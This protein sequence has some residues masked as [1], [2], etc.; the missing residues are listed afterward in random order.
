MSSSYL[1]MR[2][3]DMHAM[4]RRNNFF[5][6]LTSTRVLVL[7]TIVINKADVSRRREKL[8]FGIASSARW[9]NPPF[10]LFL[11]FPQKKNLVFEK[12]ELCSMVEG[13]DSARKATRLYYAPC[14]THNDTKIWQWREIYLEKI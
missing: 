7:T 10:A 8:A 1:H 4:C 6:I 11:A 9:T 12:E 5:L 14:L 3:Y 2:Q 13:K